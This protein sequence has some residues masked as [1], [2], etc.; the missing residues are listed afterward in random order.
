MAGS[1]ARD[2]IGKKPLVYA[3]TPEGFAFASELRCL[4]KL[5]PGLSREI[6]PTALDRCFIEFRPFIDRC[7]FR[8]CRH[9]AEPGCAVRAAV[10]T[11]ELSASRY[12]S[13][14][15]LHDELAQRR[16]EW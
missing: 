4:F 12:D 16:G 6:E 2:R 8:D 11:G 10:A 7:R 15:R 5:L 14:L 1:G 3:D 9:A 13:Y